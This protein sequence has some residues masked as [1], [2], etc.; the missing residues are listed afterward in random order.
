MS[1]LNMQDF[2]KG[3]TIKYPYFKIENPDESLQLMCM[4]LEE[5]EFPLCLDYSNTL[6]KLMTI[7]KS[8][9]NVD[10]LLKIGTL[11][12]VTAFGQFEIKTIQDYLEGVSVWIC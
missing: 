6:Y 9:Y 3:V 8:A 11:S 12:I 2:S 5:G 4:N 7:S 10:R 1:S